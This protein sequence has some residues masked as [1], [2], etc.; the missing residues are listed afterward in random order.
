MKIL[1]QNLKRENLTRSKKTAKPLV[2]PEKNRNPENINVILEGHYLV[3]ST[4]VSKSQ[5][6]PTMLWAK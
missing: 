4:G 2:A 5:D 3:I 1:N 6:N